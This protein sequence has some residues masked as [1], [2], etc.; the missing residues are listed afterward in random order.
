MYREPLLYSKGI[1]NNRYRTPDNY[2]L[3]NGKQNDSAKLREC[4]YMQIM[5]LKVHHKNCANYGGNL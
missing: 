1:S 2:V 3:C 5:Y 4:V